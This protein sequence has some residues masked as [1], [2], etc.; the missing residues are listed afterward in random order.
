MLTISTRQ[1]KQ[2]P[3]AAID[4]VLTAGE[5]AEI[6]SYGKPTGAVLAPAGVRRP[7][8]WVSAAALRAGLTPL[9]KDVAR[10]WKA[11]L[12]EGRQ[13]EFGRDLWG[14]DE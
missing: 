4:Q 2:N 3:A 8:T 13:Y 1:L 7:Q 9:P 12:E 11:D 10:A 14:D 5:P 6:T